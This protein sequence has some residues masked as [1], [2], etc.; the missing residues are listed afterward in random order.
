MAVVLGR[1]FKAYYSPGPETLGSG[2]EPTDVN[3]TDFAVI[4]TVR[5]LNLNLEKG[6]IDITTRGN[7]GWTAYAAGLKDGEVTFQMPWDP[8]DSAFADLVGFWENDTLFAAMFLDGDKGTIGKQ[9]FAANFLCTNFSRSEPID[10][11]GQ[12]DVTLL[13]YSEQQWY[14]VSS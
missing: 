10:G 12:A 14:T 6:E 1:N 2:D 11:A 4:D 7:S 9:G 13:P 5:D 8:A 3:I